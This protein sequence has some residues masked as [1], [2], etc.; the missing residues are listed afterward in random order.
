MVLL[1]VLGRRGAL[2]VLWELRDERQLTFRALTDACESNPGG[3]NTRLRELRELGL[4][5]HEPGGYRLTAHGREI[6][7]LLILLN[8]AANRWSAA[9]GV[10]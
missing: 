3:L 7:Q 4:V 6:G 9:E 5:E 8:Q 1:D 10:G 2:R